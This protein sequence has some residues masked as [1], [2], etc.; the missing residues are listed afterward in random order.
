MNNEKYYK[1]ALYLLAAIALALV[2]SKIAGYVKNQF[3]VLENKDAAD[4]MFVSICT[5]GNGFP[6]M[7]GSCGM[8][9]EALQKELNA[10]NGAALKIDGKFGQKTKHAL[11][12]ATNKSQIT[13]LEFS[14]YQ[15]KQAKPAHHTE[16]ENAKSAEQQT[17]TQK[18]D[19]AKRIEYIAD[20]VRRDLNTTYLFERRKNVGIWPVFIGLSLSDVRKV[21]DLYNS[22]YVRKLYNDVRTSIWDT[23]ESADVLVLKRIL[24]AIG[25]FQAS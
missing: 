4:S 22:K 11:Y 10:R 16:K 6:L 2:I 19:A 15:K 7:V 1:I 23:N 8:N 21:N 24:D 13:A 3:H 17:Y 9:V 12:L 5:K 25:F 14:D 20:E 18:L